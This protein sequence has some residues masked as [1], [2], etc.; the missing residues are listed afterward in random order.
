M[1]NTLR[2]A[3][4]L[5]AIADVST[6]QVLLQ[7]AIPGRRGNLSLFTAEGPKRWR[8]DASLMKRIRVAE[9]KSVQFRLDATNVFNHP[10][11][12]TANLIM[13]INT[14][15]FGF[16]TTSNT[17]GPKTDLRRQFQAQLRFEF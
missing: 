16:F 14:A 3:C 9:K 17:A 1:V 6:N 15:N 2:D 11:P 5:N 4:T 7:N 12:N 10:E 13:N 8:F